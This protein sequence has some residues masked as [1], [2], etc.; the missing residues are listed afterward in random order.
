[1]F[2]LQH[3][4]K[5]H[6]THT[7]V[8]VHSE[9]MM[10]TLYSITWLVGPEQLGAS[11]G[12]P[13]ISRTAWHHIVGPQFQEQLCTT[14]LAHNFK[15][16]CASHGWPTISRTAVHHMVGAQFQEQLCTPHGW[17]T[18]S[19]TAWHH[20]VGPQ[21]QEQLCTTWL[22]H[23]FKN[24]CASHG[25]PTISRTA[26]HTAWLAHNFKNSTCYSFNYVSSNKPFKKS[27]VNTTQ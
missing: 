6:T 19:R 23:N 26:V 10:I 12:W 5:P 21:F 13:T 15:N 3:I 8:D 24:S 9:D 20:I 27:N 2:V 14:W 1:M 18:I 17:P 22:A 11:H 16:S 4:Y 7:Y 25:W